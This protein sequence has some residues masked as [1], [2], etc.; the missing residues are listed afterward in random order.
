[1][2]KLTVSK[3]KKMR[4]HGSVRGHK[5]TKAQKGMFGDRAGGAKL[6]KA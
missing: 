3:A 6:R 1:M 5:L 4:K 2:A